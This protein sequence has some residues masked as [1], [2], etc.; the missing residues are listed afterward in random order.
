MNHSPAP[1]QKHEHD[2]NSTWMERTNLTTS[3]SKHKTH[4]K[5]SEIVQ[6]LYHNSI[7]TIPI[8]GPVISSVT[9]SYHRQQG[10]FYICTNVICFYSNVLGLEQKLCIPIEELISISV[11][12]NTSILF[13]CLTR[14]TK[15]I[16][17]KQ[18]EEDQQEQ[19]A[20]P[21]VEYIFRSFRD[22]LAVM[23]L[24]RKVHFD[25][26]GGSSLHA[27]TSLPSHG[28]GNIKPEETNTLELTPNKAGTGIPLPSPLVVHHNIPS[29]LS[30][31]PIKF[32]A[33][34]QIAIP[35]TRFNLSIDEYYETFLANDA[36]KSMLWFQSHCLGDQ[37]T[38]C[39]PWKE[40]A[41]QE[42]TRIF[43]ALH[44][45]KRKVG[46]SK[47]S[48]ERKQHLLWSENSSCITLY[49][50]LKL[51][52]VPYSDC[53]WIEDEWIITSLGESCVEMV[54]RYRVHFIKK[55]IMKKVIMKQTEDEIMKWFDAYL[56]MLNDELSL[57]VEKKAL[58]HMSHEEKSKESHFS[59]TFLNKSVAFLIIIIGSVL[60]FVLIDILLKMRN[61]EAQMVQYRLDHDQVMKQLKGLGDDVNHL[62]LLSVEGL[63]RQICLA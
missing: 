48:I 42:C 28:H 33:S 23:D 16:T 19:E 18:K 20:L 45:R 22:R 40:I 30:P 36:P 27:E 7:P 57:G 38:E 54:V 14:E 2:A 24:I 58:N 13:K 60:I 31:S 59:N 21:V 49:T 8:I 1:H 56:E 53:F 52:G 15:S 32:D 43:K 46:P 5:E 12:R 25:I 44:R 9:S 10:R 39:T 26:T 11:V 50:S 55:T 41:P 62:S 61:L 17:T 35:P 29:N 37:V 3:P 63:N 51:E 47:V 4:S 34:H 6:Y